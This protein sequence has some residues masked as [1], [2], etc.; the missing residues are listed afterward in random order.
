MID[1][2]LCSPVDASR[3]STE[4]KQM[5][6]RVVRVVLAALLVC[7]SGGYT[8][9]AGTAEPAAGTGEAPTR[10]VVD[11]LG[12]TVRVPVDPQRIA[13]AGQSVL[14]IADALYMFPSA[15]DLLVGVGRIDQGKGNFLRA[16]DPN[17]DEKTFFERNVGPVQIAAVNPD[18]VILKTSMQQRLGEGLE[19][20]GIPTVYVNLETPEDYRTDIALLGHVLGEEERAAEIVEYYG[21]QTAAVERAVAESAPGDTPDRA[22]RAEDGGARPRTLFAYADLTTGE[23]VINVPPAEWIQTTLVR[24]AG[25]DPVWPDAAV[26]RGWSRVNLE[27]VAAWSP[28]VV[29]LV[30]Y[31]QDIESVAEALLGNSVWSEIISRDKTRL[32]RFPLDFYSWDQPDVRWILGL[33]WLAGVLNPETYDPDMPV[34]ICDFFAFAY[35]MTDAEVEQIILPRIEGDVDWGETAE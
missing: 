25:G 9:A 1:A 11:A 34:L 26:G 13:T 19:R 22:A 2:R 21:E 7:V 12:R 31:R 10:T 27:Q 4:T 32:L 35:G 8:S 14:M 24:L 18:L 5:I 3:R 23:G 28:E 16:I 6:A 17:Y 15:R 30:A 29:L 33:H 20:L